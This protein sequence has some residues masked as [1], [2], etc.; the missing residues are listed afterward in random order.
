MHT[1]CQR[2]DIF[3]RAKHTKI[4]CIKINIQTWIIY[5]SPHEAHLKSFLLPKT[6]MRQNHER[7]LFKNL[8]IIWRE[9]PLKTTYSINIL[10]GRQA[11]SVIFTNTYINSS[12]LTLFYKFF[13]C[14]V[15]SIKTNEYQITIPFNALHFNVYRSK[16]D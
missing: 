2:K 7:S 9:S 12:D 10:P 5:S 6:R 4:Q 15:K 16:D 8:K 11:L 14:F 1:Q 13:T 3:F